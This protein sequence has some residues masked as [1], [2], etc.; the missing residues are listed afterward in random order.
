M[1][2]RPSTKHIVI[3]GGNMFALMHKLEEMKTSLQF[4]HWEPLKGEWPT[5]EEV[6]NLT[7]I[8]WLEDDE[9]LEWEHNYYEDRFPVLKQY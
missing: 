9:I 2:T 1:S 3:D 4:M 5:K 7:E 6:N 8:T